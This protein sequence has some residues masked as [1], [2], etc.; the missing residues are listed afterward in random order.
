M[1]KTI[2]NNNIAK[3]PITALCILLT[4][5]MKLKLTIAIHLLK[6]S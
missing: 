5:A 6:M 1:S 4:Y 2:V 3:S